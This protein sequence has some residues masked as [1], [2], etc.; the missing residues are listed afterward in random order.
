MSFQPATPLG[1]VAGWAFLNRTLERQSASF[2]DSSEVAR[3]TAYFRDN[4]GKVTDAAGLVSDHRLLRVALGAFGLDS[5]IDKRF[6]VRKVL[7]EGTA[8][9]ASMANRLVDKRYARLADAF[10]F[11]NPFGARTARPQAMATITA[12]FETRQFEIAVGNSDPSLRL[13][14]GFR[15]EIAALAEAGGA[16]G[17]YGL[18]GNIPVRKVLVEGFGLPTSFAG[19]DIDR[20]VATLQ[21]RTASLYGSG[22]IAVFSDPDRVEDTIRRYLA[23]SGASNS[24]IASG[25]AATALSL[26][27]ASQS[28]NSGVAS[29]EALF[30]ALY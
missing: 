9:P 21:D 22:D 10:G 8:D 5:D 1:G 13:A 26:L 14:L 11:D 3:E 12:A 6:F 15:R 29:L 20:Q 30:S 19:L 4:I 23:R 17:W 25:P 24:S 18:L 27:Q 28:R 2:R 16:T 7:E